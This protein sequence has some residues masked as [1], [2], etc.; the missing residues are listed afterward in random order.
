MLHCPTAKFLPIFTK[1]QITKFVI[2]RPIVIFV[3]NFYFSGFSQFSHAIQLEKRCMSEIGVI[4]WK[5]DIA[6]ESSSCDNDVWIDFP[7]S[8]DIREGGKT[9]LLMRNDRFS[10]KD[11][12]WL[13]D[14]TKTHNFAQNICEKFTKIWA[15]IWTK[16]CE[17]LLLYTAID[18]PIW[19]HFSGL[20]FLLLRYCGTTKSLWMYFG[21]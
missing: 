10:A 19:I 9:S 13:L 5:P 3:T 21:L 16:N 15:K 14:M 4:W 6:W 8:F 20:G 11:E 2:D 18:D 1:S 17:K 12:V 7:M